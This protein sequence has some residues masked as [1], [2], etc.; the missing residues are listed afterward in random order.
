MTKPD[1]AMQRLYNQGLEPPRFKDPSEV[2]AWLGAVQAQDYMSAKWA[3]GLRVKDITDA[4]VEQAIANKTIVRTWP[5]RGTI[6]FV[7][8]DNV[9]WML[10]LLTPRVI[11]RS[12]GRYRQLELDDAVFSKSRDILETALQGGKQLTREALY[13]ALNAAHIATANG[14]GLH[15]LGHLAQEGLVCFGPREGKQP[16]F[17]L[18]EEWVQPTK[19]LGRD[20]ALA[21]LTK[22]YF[23]SHG[24]ATL[25]DF[26]WWSGLTV[27]DARIGLELA[28]THLIHARI[29]E[30]IYWFAQNAPLKEVLP[31]AYLLPWFDEFLVS[32]KDR[33]AVL[34]PSYTKAVNAGGGLLNPT[35]IVNGQVVGTWKR[36]VQKDTV[37]LSLTPFCPLNEIEKQSL[38]DAVERY[39]NFLSKSVSLPEI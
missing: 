21:E 27:A 3:L 31:T 14:R 39:G 17:A 36:T 35:L 38:A 25:E 16:T 2:V 13:E 19:R 15:I 8:P 7:S 23:T 6:H 37:T 9:R 26:V 22:R 11:A 24:P 34:N 32:Y 10:W 33:S 4:D 30:K 28:K 29:E 18:L 12:A 1:I 20:E 5:M